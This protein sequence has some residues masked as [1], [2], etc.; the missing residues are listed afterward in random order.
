MANPIVITVS[1]DQAELVGEAF[2]RH[3]GYAPTPDVDET[4]EDVEV[5]ELT[6]EQILDKK[7]DFARERIVAYV[8]DVVKQHLEWQHRQTMPEVSDTP[9]NLT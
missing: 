2:A 1:A 8:Q 4:E 5:P 7:A 6:P 3:F 9:L